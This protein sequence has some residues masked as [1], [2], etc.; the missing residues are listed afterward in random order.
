MGSGGDWGER[1]GAS[2]E[3]NGVALCGAGGGGGEEICGDL[4]S[5]Y[6]K[7]QLVEEEEKR[8]EERRKTIES[9]EYHNHKDRKVN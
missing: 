9:D 2:W 7:Q 6:A 5:V 4:R 1:R 3:R 8:Y